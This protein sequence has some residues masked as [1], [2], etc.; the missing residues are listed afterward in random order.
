MITKPIIGIPVSLFLEK[1]E[2]VRE[3]TV[4][5]LYLTKKLLARKY[6]EKVVK[7]VKRTYPNLKEGDGTHRL[8]AAYEKAAYTSVAYTVDQ[9][10]PRPR[11]FVF[12]EQL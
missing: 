9:D 7:H 6:Q 8:R 3:T 4:K 2:K 11:D 1:L 5:D 12:Y 10:S